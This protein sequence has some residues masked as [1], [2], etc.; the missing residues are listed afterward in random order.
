MGYLR[1]HTNCS[2]TYCLVRMECWTGNSLQHTNF[3]LKCGRPIYG[4]SSWWN[5]YF[6]W[7]TSCNFSNERSCLNRLKHYTRSN[8]LNIMFRQIFMRVCV[9]GLQLVYGQVYVRIDPLRAYGCIRTNDE[10]CLLF[11]WCDMLTFRSCV[12]W[13]LLRIQRWWILAVNLWIPDC[14]CGYLAHTNVDNFQ[15]RAY[16]LPYIST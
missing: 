3:K 1:Q 9:R 14:F 10:Y 12:A 16:L 5:N 2:R 8:S 6:W 11:L 15:I 13:F 4:I 7:T